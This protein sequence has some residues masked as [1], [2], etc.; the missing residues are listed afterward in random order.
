MSITE[1]NTVLSLRAVGAS[2][3]AS[4]TISGDV[5]SYRN[6]YP[7]TMVSL[8]AV[9]GSVEFSFTLASPDARR[10]FKLSL[11]LP[12]GLR[13][14]LSKRALLLFDAR[15][16]VRLQIP[17]PMMLVHTAHGLVPSYAGSSRVRVSLTRSGDGV[18]LGYA[19]NQAWL[20]AQHLRFPVV[21]DPSPVTSSP[22]AGADCS[23]YSNAPSSDG[24]CGSSEAYDMVGSDVTGI[25]GAT[26]G[27]FETM[28]NFPVGSTG[29]NIPADSQVLG[30]DLSMTY[31]LLG[32]PVSYAVLPMAD[33][34]TPYKASWNYYDADTNGKWS[35]PGGDFEGCQSGV[36]S[37]VAAYAE[38]SGAATTTSVSLTALAQAWVDGSQPEWP[39]GAYEYWPLMLY[40]TTT[41]GDAEIGRFGT[42]STS[43]QLTIYYTETVRPSVCEVVVLV[44]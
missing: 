11:V 10:V 5:A 15:G 40:P 4:A 7:G 20:A 12:R 8:R 16:R 34:F 14:R 43:P 41:Q 33:S 42:G 39:L 25:G 31:T 28:M 23:I 18:I 36:P 19:I 24:Y 13:A 6:A 27:T 35:C 21:L 30:A 22:G 37:T 26:A 17:A 9:P 29:I 32:S 3:S 2:G 38:F 44:G 1:G